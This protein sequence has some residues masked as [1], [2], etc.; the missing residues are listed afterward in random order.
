MNVASRL[1]NPWFWVGLAG[2]IFTAMGINPEML[3]SWDAVV[4]SFKHLIGN[5]FMLGTVAF[6]I[7]GVFVD[8]ST[9]GLSDSVAEMIS[10]VVTSDVIADVIEAVTDEAMEE[11]IAEMVTENVTQDVL[12]D[13]EIETTVEKAT[14]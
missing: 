4:H 6:A 14:I 1:K 12:G 8:P 3:T 5:P 7:L 11:A 13:V 9:A 10:E 2:V